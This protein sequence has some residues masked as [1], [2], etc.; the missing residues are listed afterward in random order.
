[1]EQIE[2]IGEKSPSKST[3]QMLAKG[4]REES[5]D[6]QGTMALQHV[7][8]FLPQYGLFFSI[9]LTAT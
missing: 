9:F 2:Q 4:V 6:E 3:P 1:M 8:K 5:Q 7:C